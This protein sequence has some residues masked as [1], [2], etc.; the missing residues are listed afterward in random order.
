MV[1]IHSYRIVKKE[2]SGNIWHIKPEETPL[3]PTCNGQ[4]TVAGSRKRKTR[5]IDGTPAWYVFRRLYCGNCGVTH[6]EIPDIVIPYKRYSTEAIKYVLSQADSNDAMFSF[7]GETSTIYRLRK[8]Y[9]EELRQGRDILKEAGPVE[10][11]GL[12]QEPGLREKSAGPEELG[13]REEA[14]G[15]EELGM[16]EEAAGRRN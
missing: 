15:P 16:R 11:A 1:K 14:A 7:A 9:E 3:C 10:K 5:G 4:V 12:R 2:G 8:W 6:H 13:M